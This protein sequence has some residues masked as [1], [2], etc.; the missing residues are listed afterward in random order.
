MRAS[1]RMC[2]FVLPFLLGAAACG[3]AEELGD[4]IQ[5]GLVE[6]RILGKGG[7]SGD[8]IDLELRKTPKAGDAPLTLSVST[9]LLLDS[10]DGAYQDMVV[11]RVKGRIVDAYRYD[12]ANEI[13]LD[14]N[15]E[16]SYLAEAY[17][18]EFEKGNPTRRTEFSVTKPDQALT[19]VLERAKAGQLS[20]RATQA[21]IWIVTDDVTYERLAGKFPVSEEEWEAAKDA[22]ANCADLPRAIPPK[23]KAESEG[24]QSPERKP[25]AEP[26]EKPKPGSRAKGTG[27]ITFSDPRLEEEQKRER[28]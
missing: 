2:V 26:K 7:S 12:P 21:A 28:R 17:C 1:R 25:K 4:A 16:Q 9:G 22:A 18:A 6:A 13:V 5:Q 11:S 10:R 24:E 15:E 3:W 14:S 23:E 19:C 20:V 27:S 8:T